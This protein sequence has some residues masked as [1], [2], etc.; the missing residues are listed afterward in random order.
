MK[1]LILIAF[2]SLFLMTSCKKTSQENPQPA[3]PAQTTH[4]M[5]IMFTRANWMAAYLINNSGYVAIDST[6]SSPTI[7]TFTAKDNDSLYVFVSNNTIGHP[8]VAFDLYILQD[9]IIVADTSVIASD[10]NAELIYKIK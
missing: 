7:V 10:I 5:E 3:T 8:G 4:N 6:S 2:T 9:N 1:K